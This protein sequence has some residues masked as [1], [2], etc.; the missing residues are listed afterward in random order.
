M[1]FYF[2]GLFC[3]SLFTRVHRA[4][5][6]FPAAAV[7]P[8][9]KDNVLSLGSCRRTS[10][11]TFICLDRMLGRFISLGTSVA[12]VV[13]LSSHSH[14]SLALQNYIL[15]YVQFGIWTTPFRGMI[16]IPPMQ[17]LSSSR[18]RCGNRKKSLFHTFFFVS[19]LLGVCTYACSCKLY[20]FLCLYAIVVLAPHHLIFFLRQKFSSIFL[21][22]L[23]LAS[24]WFYSYTGDVV[25]RHEHLILAD[26]LRPH[27]SKSSI[28][29]S[30]RWE[31]VITL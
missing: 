16:C 3:D 29:D 2:S 31:H 14:L 19:N 9:T 24:Y 1:I 27:S 17:Q 22:D 11:F 13:S 8:A 23:F 7:R 6:L 21:S 28:K 10:P 20:P 30:H 25:T 26:R 5:S 12:H 4:Y 18:M 15:N